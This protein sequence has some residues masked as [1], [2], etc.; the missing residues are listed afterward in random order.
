MAGKRIFEEALRSTEITLHT[1]SDTH[2]HVACIPLCGKLVGCEH[3]QC[4]CAH[5]QCACISV[6]SVS[7]FQ[8]LKCTRCNETRDKRR[9]KYHNKTG[10][11]EWINKLQDKNIIKYRERVNTNENRKFKNKHTVELKH[12]TLRVTGRSKSRMDSVLALSPFVSAKTAMLIGMAVTLEIWCVWGTSSILAVYRLTVSAEM[13]HMC[14]P[15][16][17]M[18]LIMRLILASCRMAI[19]I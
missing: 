14:P 11:R 9:G 16:P 7:V 4:V 13:Q 12:V 6:F 2:T 15:D 19:H 17:N 18:T 8:C 5:Y 10:S 1:H 3:F